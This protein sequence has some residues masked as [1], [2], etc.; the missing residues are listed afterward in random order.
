M[1][2]DFSGGADDAASACVSAHFSR[3]ERSARYFALIKCDD[4]AML[5]PPARAL[6][7]V[8]VSYI[9][10]IVVDRAGIGRSSW[11][12]P[13]GIEKPW[14]RRCGGGCG[15]LGNRIFN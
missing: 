14:A 11:E 10:F 4:T 13:R 7:I 12:L 6:A 2:P 3:N 9:V 5:C 8:T 15:K 1:D